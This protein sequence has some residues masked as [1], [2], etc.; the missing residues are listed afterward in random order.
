MKSSGLGAPFLSQKSNTGIRLRADGDGP[1]GCRGE[2]SGYAERSPF[3]YLLIISGV[4]E[5]PKE[6]LGWDLREWGKVVPLHSQ[7]REGYAPKVLRQRSGRAGRGKRIFRIACRN[8]N[9]SYLCTH[10]AARGAGD[11]E[12]RDH[13]HKDKTRASPFLEIRSERCELC[14]YKTRKQVVYQFSRWDSNS[15]T[16][17]ET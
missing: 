13:R 4:R 10:I 8:E 5:Y 3:F 7:S 1:P 2:G 17:S 14:K 15:V 6:I 16:S 12:K 9:L 11:A